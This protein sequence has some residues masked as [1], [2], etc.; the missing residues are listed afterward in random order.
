M[1]FRDGRKEVDVP[2]WLAKVNGARGGDGAESVWANTRAA[3]PALREINLRARSVKFRR[4]KRVSMRNAQG[5]TS[6][7]PNCLRPCAAVGSFT[8]RAA[9]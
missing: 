5:S 2:A 9:T 1:A 3:I 6:T 7:S 8:K 4:I